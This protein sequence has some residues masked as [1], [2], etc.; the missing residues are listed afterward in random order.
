MCE[1]R[2]GGVSGRGDKLKASV[3]FRVNN[4][5]VIRKVQV[6]IGCCNMRVEAGK[7][8]AVVVHAVVSVA[9]CGVTETV[10]RL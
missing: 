9:A 1:W 4:K 3:G 5:T 6:V 8:H 10:T 7:G 2:Q